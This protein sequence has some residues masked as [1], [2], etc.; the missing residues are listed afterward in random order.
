MDKMLDMQ[1]RLETAFPVSFVESDF[2]WDWLAFNDFKLDVTLNHVLNIPPG[3][4]SWSEDD[5]KGYLF[6]MRGAMHRGEDS[7]LEH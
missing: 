2:C 4:L 5:K 1:T 6:M 3:F 7:F